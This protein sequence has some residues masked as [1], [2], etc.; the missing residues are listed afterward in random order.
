[1]GGGGDHNLIYTIA[2]SSDNSRILETGVAFGFSSLALL[3]GVKDVT[4][5]KLISNDFPYVGGTGEPC[6][7]KAVPNSLAEDSEWKIFRLPDR[8]FITWVLPFL[9]PFDLI[10]YDSA[11]GYGPRRFAYKRLWKKL[12]PGG[13]L[14]SDDIGDNLGF[15]H[16]VESLRDADYVEYVLAGDYVKSGDK[17]IG[18]VKKATL[19][20]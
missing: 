13:L 11:K 18:V 4:G 17:F 9:K 14:I 12:R 2:K 19:S 1:M 7:S 5:A 10:H 20:K 15:S 16:F 8:D 3:L 6:F